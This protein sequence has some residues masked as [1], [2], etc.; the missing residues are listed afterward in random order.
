[1]DGMIRKRI[2]RIPS[3]NLFLFMFTSFRKG[4]RW[5]K[6]TFKPLTGFEYWKGLCP[7][8]FPI[9][10]ITGE[11]GPLAGRERILEAN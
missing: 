8:G 2:S 3:H 6:G 9:Y 5:V 10:W 1:M 11:P 4:L 7:P